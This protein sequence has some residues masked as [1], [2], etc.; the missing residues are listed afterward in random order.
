MQKSLSNLELSE[1]QKS[2]MSSF[3]DNKRS[4]IKYGELKEQDFVRITELGYGNGGV[5]WKV[6]HTPSGIVMAR[7]VLHLE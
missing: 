4:I 7:K 5:V 2:N 1:E 6:E 3:L